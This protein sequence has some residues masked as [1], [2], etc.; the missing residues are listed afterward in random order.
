MRTGVFSDAS[1]D[2][3]DKCRRHYP[4]AGTP[5]LIGHCVDITVVARKITTPVHLQ[6]KLPEWSGLPTSSYES[7]DI[8]LF[9]PVSANVAHILS[10]DRHV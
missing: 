7:V 6:K 4:G 3:G 10:A 5:R 1:S 8:E 9:R 2:H